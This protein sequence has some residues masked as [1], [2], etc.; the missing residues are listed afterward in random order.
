MAPPAIGGAPWRRFEVTRFSTSYAKVVVTFTR[1]N[2]ARHVAIVVITESD[3][4][5][6]RVGDGSQ[7]LQRTVN[8]GSRLYSLRDSSEVVKRVVKVAGKVIQAARVFVNC[9][10]SSQCIG[11]ARAGLPCLICRSNGVAEVATADDRIVRRGYRNYA[12]Q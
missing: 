10:H 3:S 7:P 6:F 5:A 1:V 9:N 2:S 12:S 4:A 11:H 8:K